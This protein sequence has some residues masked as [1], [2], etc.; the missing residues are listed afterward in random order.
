[1]ILFSYDIFGSQRT[2]GIS[3]C[4]IE[5][6]S[7][8][9]STKI[10]WRLWAGQHQNLMLESARTDP[11]FNNQLLEATCRP[12]MSRFGSTLRN[13]YSF[14]SF[15]RNLKPDVVHRTYFPIID[16]S[17]A[18][19]PRVETVHD[20]WDERAKREGK[21][22]S[23]FKS[24]IKKRALDRADAIIC[25]S[26]STHTE[27]LSLWPQLESRC[28]IIPHGARRLST[29]PHSIEVE[30]PFF[31]FVG[32]RD[33]YKNFIITLK[34]LC[35]PYLKDHTIICFGGGAFSAHE[36]AVI[37][38]HGLSRR[39]RQIGGADALLAGLYEKA[40]A[41]LYPSRY[42]G[43]GL[44]LLEAM[45]HG[46]PVIATPLTSLPEVG[47]DAAL[48]A[49]AD[50]QEAWSGVMLSLTENSVIRQQC[51]TKG[52]ERARNF[53]WEECAKSHSHVYNSLV[54]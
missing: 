32:K 50:D 15:V 18:M 51:I 12:Y 24:L 33:L 49:D 3:R 54:R 48:Y 4:M 41:L 23:V 22:S 6:M 16:I 9:T 11:F 34:A 29:S 5:L 13:E 26:Q 1:M 20:M 27:L 30:K 19:I 8:L 21:E 46:C 47:G 52:F 45:I 31:L 53:T 39:V 7:S 40:T 37:A 2:G 25:V 28:H 14:S 43:F 17:P 38:S 42:E 35:D 10:N 44:P 36:N